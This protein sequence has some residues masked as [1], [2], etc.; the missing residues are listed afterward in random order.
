MNHWICDKCKKSFDRTNLTEIFAWGL[1]VCSP[2]IE[3]WIPDF[4]NRM[5]PE[6]LPNLS[7]ANIKKSYVASKLA[8][9][10]GKI[11]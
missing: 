5:N 4:S 6:I 1:Y 7:D 2:C 11:E 3:E 10:K 8:E 9:E